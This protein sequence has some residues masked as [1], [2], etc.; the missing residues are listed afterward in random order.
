MKQDY[1]SVG[2]QHLL[3]PTRSRFLSDRIMSVNVNAY[4]VDDVLRVSSR[5][6]YGALEGAFPLDVFSISLVPTAI[7]SF[8]HH[9]SPAYVDGFDY[10]VKKEERNSKKSASK[11]SK[12]TFKSASK[13]KLKSQTLPIEGFEGE[14]KVVRDPSVLEEEIK[15]DVSLRSSESPSFSRKLSLGLANP[16]TTWVRSWENA[17]NRAL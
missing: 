17:Y 8:I 12:A 13:A 3:M 14:I 6:L 5:E 11:K 10:Y 1:M 9:F 15:A 7:R 2:V 4:P 16:A